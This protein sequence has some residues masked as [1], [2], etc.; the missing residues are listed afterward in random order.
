MSS[1]NS[2]LGLQPPAKVAIKTFMGLLWGGVALTLLFF[3]FRIYVRIKTFHRL[4]W[5]DFLLLVAWFMLLA[6]AT[7]WQYAKTGLYLLLNVQS[8]RQLP[9]ADFGL[10]VG[11]Y[12]HESVAILVLFYSSLW[13]V[14]LSFLVFFRRLG[15]KVQKQKIIWWSVLVVVV[16]GYFSVLG[17]IQWHCL[18]P[19][20][21]I[22]AQ[23]C[24]TPSS[25]AFERAT[26]RATCAIDII[27]DAIIILVPLNMLWRV[28]IS[29]RRKLGLAGIFSLT[30]FIMII[31]IIRVTVM[32]GHR[33]QADG[34]WLWTWSSI[35]V[36]VAII[37]ACLASFRAL[38][39]QQ[40]RSQ[41]IP[42]VKGVS[43]RTKLHGNKTKSFVALWV[44]EKT[45]TIISSLNKWSRPVNDDASPDQNLA[46]S[47][48]VVHVQR[49][50]DVV[51]NVKRPCEVV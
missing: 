44:I 9:P 23:N 22:I 32:Y 42:E 21:E 45:S 40:D 1:L 26:L 8:G 13:C 38:F 12:L 10:K 47:S 24:T 15:Q 34:T 43:D 33:A 28:Q 30:V 18:I 39:I 2:P 27:T 50:F 11:E 17:T 4:F 37:V 35:E 14:K 46:T 25:R 41:R 31:A 20:F 3:A 5:D 6:N 49:D 48:E 36:T 19:R 7:I 16:A 51:S 29:L